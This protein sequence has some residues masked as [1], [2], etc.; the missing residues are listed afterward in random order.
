[1]VTTNMLIFKVIFEIFLQQRKNNGAAGIHHLLSLYYSPLQIHN[2][3]KVIFRISSNADSILV[4]DTDFVHLFYQIFVLASY[5]YWY[6]CLQKE[7]TF[8]FSGEFFHYMPEV[9]SKRKV[10]GVTWCI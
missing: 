6:L 3:Y 10:A 7:C 8:W 2:T 4:L 9:I 5:N 1:M